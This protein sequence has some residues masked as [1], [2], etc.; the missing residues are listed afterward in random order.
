MSRVYS[1]DINGG[2]Q[3]VEDIKESVQST[4]TDKVVQQWGSFGGIFDVNFLKEYKHPLLVSSCDGTGSKILLSKK[5]NRLHD[6][7]HDLVHHCINDIIVQ[8]ATPLFLLDTVSSAK[9]NI[10]DTVTVVKGVAE[11]CKEHGVAL[12]GGETAEIKNLYQKDTINLEGTIVGVVEKDE[13]IDGKRNVVKG[14]VAM[15][16]PSNNFH[17][18][19]YSLVNEYAEEYKG[20][21]D[22]LTIHRCYL[23]EFQKVKKSKIPIHAMVHITGG[24]LI[25][26]PKRV[27]PVGLQLHLE[28]LPVPKL[29]DWIQ[30]VSRCPTDEMMKTFNMGVGFLFIIPPEQEDAFKEILPESFRMGIIK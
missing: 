17:T 10:Q 14:D 18:N 2:N 29:F 5:W 11:A 22:L 13:L 3:V 23:H 26:N 27:L 25:E 9:L 21:D 20:E 28:Y 6:I 1:V 30:N 4:Y 24:G 19:G 7:G 8:G 12:L 16:L 15:A